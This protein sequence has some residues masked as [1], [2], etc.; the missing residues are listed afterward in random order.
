MRKS[1]SVRDLLVVSRLQNQG[2]LLG[3]EETLTQTYSP[4]VEALVGYLPIDGIGTLT[5]VCDEMEEGQRVKGFG[6]M[7]MRKDASKADAVYLAPSLSSE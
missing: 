1:L 5:C 4:L 7:R 3:L 2:M 6:Q